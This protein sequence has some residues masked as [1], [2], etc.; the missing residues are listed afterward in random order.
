MWKS[1]LVQENIDIM[2][3]LTIQLRCKCLLESRY[4]SIH[5]SGTRLT[6]ASLLNG[7]Q[8]MPRAWGT[9]ISVIGE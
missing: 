7:V 3:P 1:G 4:P 6:M 2:F 9:L 5:A 8:L